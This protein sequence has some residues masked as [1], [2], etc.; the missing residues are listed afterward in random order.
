MTWASERDA[1]GRF[2]QTGST[3]CEVPS[4]PKLK[5]KVVPAGIA[6]PGTRIMGVLLFCPYSNDWGMWMA[7]RRVSSLNEYGASPGAL[8][9]YIFSMGGGFLFSRELIS[10]SV[11]PF[12]RFKYVGWYQ[13]CFCDAV[14]R[15]LDTGCSIG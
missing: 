2:S 13:A 11:Y 15:I 10:L 3:A 9:G 14:S 12:N 6:V 7:E 1:D 8:V 5:V 4:L